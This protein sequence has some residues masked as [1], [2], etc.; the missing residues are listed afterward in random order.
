MY[1]MRGDAEQKK[2]PDLLE[3]ARVSFEEEVEFE[4]DME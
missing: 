1:E 2:N 3:Q 4:L